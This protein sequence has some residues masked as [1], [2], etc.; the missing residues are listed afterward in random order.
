MCRDSPLVALKIDHTG[1]TR[2]INNGV[3]WLRSCG[4]YETTHGTRRG[5]R[6]QTLMLQHVGGDTQ[7]VRVP[8]AKL[9]QQVSPRFSE[10]PSPCFRPISASSLSPG[11]LPDFRGSS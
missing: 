4:W 6:G 3:C 7:A 2:L 9:H 5:E 8:A 11:S 1:L 10:G